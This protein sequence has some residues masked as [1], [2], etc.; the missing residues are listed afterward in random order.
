[1]TGYFVS[2]RLELFLVIAAVAILGQAG[3]SE[4]N[5]TV[6]EITPGSVAKLPCALPPLVKF[7]RIWLKDAKRIEMEIVGRPKFRHGQG[8][9][10]RGTKVALVNGD[11]KIECKAEGTQPISYRWSKEGR[12]LVQ[13]K[14]TVSEFSLKID[15]VDLSDEGTYTCIASNVFGSSVCNYTLHVTEIVRSKPFLQPDFPRSATAHVG[16]NASME[17]YE[18]FSYK[19]GTM[20]DFR[21]F[22]WLIKPNATLEQDLHKLVS[23]ANS[24]HNFRLISSLYYE[25]MRKNIN[26][27]YLYG[28][29][30]NLYN[31][32]IKDQGYYSCVACSHLGC[33]FTTANLT[34]V[35]DTELVT[36]S[37][38][39]V[40]GNRV[41]PNEN[42]ITYTIVI[43]S[44][45]A[46]I[47]VVVVIFI[48]C[49]KML[50]NRDKKRELCAEDMTTDANLN[51]KNYIVKYN[52]SNGSKVISMTSS[53]T[54]LI[55]KSSLRSSFE[56]QWSASFQRRSLQLPIALNA[57][58]YRE[59]LEIP[60][61]REWEID[62]ESL[63]LGETLG[64][65][66]FGVV[67]K[68]EALCLIPKSGSV[69]T[70]AVKMLKADATEHELHDLLSEMET[71][72]RIGQHRNIINFLGCCTQN[73]SVYVV[74]EF[75]PYGNL[76]QYLRSRRPPL[77]A[78]SDESIESEI[79]LPSLVSFSLQVS[80]GMQFL[81]D[82]KCIHRDLAARNV[83]VGKDF[84]M[85]IADFGLARNVRESDYYRK[86]TDGRLPIKWLSIEALF[87]RVYTTQ[88]DVWA[89]GVLLWEIFTL[90]GSPYPSIPVGK[91]F[92]LLKSGYRMQKPQGCPSEIYEVMLKCWYENANS[93]PTFTS[94]VNQFE[95]FLESFASMDYIEVVADS[96]D[97]IPEEEEPHESDAAELSSEQS[98][99]EETPF[100]ML[101][102]STL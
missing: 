54:P 101:E 85:K 41:S 48:V 34:V 97:C 1:M 72:K 43:A 45:C 50:R 24:T 60:L 66:A 95:K 73:G 57:E 42:K 3:R 49:W 44:G 84:V 52:D 94:L 70:V 35:Q 87:D 77:N 30:L 67:V 28:V 23:H 40:S 96:T 10:I 71:M 22:L 100:D 55:H 79:T 27:K 25:T 75:A 68:A 9:E 62:R 74:V 8:H 61:D 33:A 47:V 7:K 36:T 39:I 2:S 81:A 86:T 19:M 32:T 80:K 58:T 83:L 76:R 12:P 56:S 69:S 20:V 92:S 89:Y 21:W 26:N 16:E 17:C 59:T 46:A 14:F 93:R 90:G 99:D 64:E 102:E 4:P 37:L 91:L 31:V 5:A 51:K 98:A 13:P 88:S 38:P 53:T 15:S 65:G 11:V 82:R 63:I 29:R 6:L 78:S 18:L